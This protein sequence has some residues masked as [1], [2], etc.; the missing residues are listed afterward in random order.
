MKRRAL[1]L[2]GALAAA[3][4]RAQVHT[5]AQP[6]GVALAPTRWRAEIEALLDAD[7]RSAPPLGAVLFVGSSTIRLWKGL[8]QDFAA[9][10]PVVL[11]R[12]LGGSRL[13]EWPEFVPWLVTRY[14]PK[15]VIVYA[16]ENDIAEGAQPAEVLAA[17]VRFVQAVQAERPGTPIAF[18][19]IKPSPLRAAQA[20]TMREANLLVQTWVLAQDGLDYIDV[21]TP[22]L[23]NDGR[24]RPELFVRDRLHLSPEGYALW[25][26]VISAHLKP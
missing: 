17:F 12:G 23:D 21:H 24:A 16:G 1:L 8:E 25:R 26:Q 10:A 18:V 3:L 9:Q 20:A 13:S 14:V 7:R 4:A 11:R 22:M 6:P 5:P 15:Q 2:G 19:S